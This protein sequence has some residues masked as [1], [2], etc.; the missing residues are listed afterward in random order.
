[1]NNSEESHIALCDIVTNLRELDDEVRF[2]FWATAAINKT[3]LSNNIISLSQKAYPTASF[4]FFEFTR[5]KRGGE[6]EEQFYEIDLITDFQVLYLKRG[7]TNI[8][9]S[10]NTKSANFN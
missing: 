7:E 1:M 10:E 6:D 2:K 4:I 8:L 9:S 5:V 3:A